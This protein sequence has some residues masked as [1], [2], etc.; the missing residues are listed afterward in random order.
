[1]ENPYSQNYRFSERLVKLDEQ[2]TYLK[3][4][5]N[6]RPATSLLTTVVR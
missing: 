2:T 3:I 6:E 5:L 1:M 4:F